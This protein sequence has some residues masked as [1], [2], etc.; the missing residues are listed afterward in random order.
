MS[1]ATTLLLPLL[2]LLGACY[3]PPSDP[4]FIT[5][6]QGRA[7]ILHGLNVSS[8]AKFTDDHMPWVEQ[9][10]IDRMADDWGFNFARF[11][12]SWEAVEPQRGVYD[13]AY[14]DDVAVRLGWFADAGIHVVLDMHQDVYG[15]VDS[16]GRRIGGNGHPDWSFL[17]DGEA[18]TR[19]PIN[20]F[21]NYW[22]PA[23]TRAFDNF[24]DYD[25]HAFLQDHYAAAW[26]HVAERFRDHP[27]VIG[28]DIMN[29]PWAGSLVDV[30]E[31]LIATAFDR[32]PY[33]A[34]LERVIAS[35]RAV[36]PDGWIFYEPRA[37]GPNDG[38]PSEIGALDDPR[39]GEDRLA[40]F[41]HYYSLFVD[42]F[43]TYVPSVDDSIARWA[44]SRRAEI[45]L[46]RAP[47]LIGEW[48]ASAGVTN[49]REYLQDVARMADRLTSGWAYWSYDLGGWSPVDANREEQPQADVLV[50]AYPQRVAGTP[51]YVDYDPDTR[52]LVVAFEEKAGVTGP[53]EIF[54]PERRFFPEGF[55]LEVVEGGS[56]TSDWDAAREILSVWT[57]PTRAVHVLLIR[58]RAAATPAA[59]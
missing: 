50:R 40:Y 28:Y 39:P 2:L 5:D 32:G 23:V 4:Q 7:L 46:Q 6:D 41:P 47:L 22:T 11:L 27:W 53:T 1:R 57:D 19:N 35:I 14:L 17:S 10:D 8:D 45:D 54:V 24:W 20:W 37:W 51:L 31:P 59:L 29:E 25:G 44:A 16:D 43:E 49:F 34:F 26:A 21:L 52:L 3:A 58:P 18:F 30:P 38:Y 42:A 55:E 12:L 15:P 36:D 48:G 13:E 9:R 33:R 56:W